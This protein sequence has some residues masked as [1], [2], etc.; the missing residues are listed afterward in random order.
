[1]GAEM[2][3]TIGTEEKHDNF[4][5][6]HHFSLGFYLKR[7]SLSPTP[8]ETKKQNKTKHSNFLLFY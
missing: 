2:L 8:I 6:F 3:L 7:Q 5:V 1:M 4:E